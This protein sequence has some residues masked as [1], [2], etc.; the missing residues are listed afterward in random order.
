MAKKK[1]IFIIWI[2]EEIMKE[3]NK[4]QNNCQKILSILGQRSASIRVNT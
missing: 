4:M 2:R 1:A 3:R